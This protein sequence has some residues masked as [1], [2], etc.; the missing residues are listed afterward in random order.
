[1]RSSF[2]AKPLPVSPR[3]AESFA[4][5]A[6]PG[7]RKAE[8]FDAH[9]R[10]QPEA[11]A[12]EPQTVEAAAQPVE[13]EPPAQETAAQCGP[14]PRELALDAA[15]EALASAAESLRDARRE[16]A[17]HCMRGAL[18]VALA[19]A[20]RV[21]ERELSVDP[22]ALLP[23]VERAVELLAEAR[24]L[25]VALAPE[26]LEVLESRPEPLAALPKDQIELVADPALARSEA[27]VRGGASRIEVR[28]DSVLGMLRDELVPLWEAEVR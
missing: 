13:A 15:V 24:P 4:P 12:A 6:A 23:L 26:A 1:M 18:D 3:R 17:E 19:L 8:R 21:L 9:D 7:A 20:R 16:E 22:S 10:V 25:R 2:E 28:L 27:R 5:A 14:D 11:P